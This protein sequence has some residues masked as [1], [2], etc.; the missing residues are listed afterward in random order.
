MRF[1]LAVLVMTLIGATPSRADIAGK[2]PVLPQKPALNKTHVAF[3]Y[4]GDL[5]T[6]GREGGEARRL[7]SG[8]GLEFG[9]LFSPDGT[10][11]AFTGEY[12][13]NLDVFVVPATGGEPRRLT[14]HPGVDVAVGWTPD[15]KNILFS[16]GRTSLLAVQQAVHPAAR[17]RR[18]P[19]RGAAADGRAGGVLAGRRSIAYVPFWNR[20]AVPN[21]YIAWKHYRGGLASPI[22]IAD[23]ADSRIEKVPRE[24]SNDFCPMW[25]DGKVYFLSD[26]AGHDAL[27]LRPGNEAGQ[28]SAGE[29]R[30]TTCSPPR[31]GRT[32]S[33]TSSSARC[34]SSTRN[35]QAREVK[36]EVSPARLP[37]ARR[38]AT[39]KVAKKITD[40]VFRRPGAR[41]S[42]RPAAK[43]S[44][45]RPRKATSA[46]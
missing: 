20:R 17:R 16:S 46:T 13:G 5:W 10:Q 34:T 39:R 14:Y 28:A 44:P 8:T 29:Q 30:A 6:V 21:N 22:W 23:L 42:S 36:V 45:C 27:L 4:A 11:I 2:S 26:R 1:T 15:G 32:P 12:D 19:D 33:S 35:E 7:T 31:P 9:P 37:A 3:G 25:L 43:S 41:A 18:P 40:S 24:D 38:T